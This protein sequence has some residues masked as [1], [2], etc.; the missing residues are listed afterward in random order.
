MSIFLDSD[1][2]MFIKYS[3]IKA[4]NNAFNKIKNK[5]PDMILN[6]VNE[7]PNI[8]NSIQSSGISFIA[9]GIF[10]HQKPYVKNISQHSNWDKKY[11]ELGDLLLINNLV[12]KNPKEQTYTSKRNALL[13][14]A[15]K[16]STKK[17]DNIIP[18]NKSQWDLYLNWPKFKYKSSNS[19][20]KD[21]RFIDC[22]TEQD[23]FEGAKYLL[24]DK[25][26][27]PNDKVNISDYV[28][29]ATMPKL[30]KFKPFYCEL[31]DFFTGNSGKEF[32]DKEDLEVDDIGWSR[33]IA[34]LID[35]ISNVV[36]SNSKNTRGIFYKNGDFSEEHGLF[37]RLKNVNNIN[38]SSSDMNYTNNIEDKDEFIGISVIE[39]T[40]IINNTEDY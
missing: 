36:L 9:G 6:L 1:K 10:I 38:S 4:I 35:E 20:L 33:I 37:G 30:S 8:L 31:F 40:T 2:Q 34:D 3:I 18:D 7:L 25:N 29:T 21:A 5:E 15:K 12:I 32:I 14:Q 39:I 11:V 28:A 24:I 17:F 22:K 16:I 23:I 27:V 13:L 26:R 19:N